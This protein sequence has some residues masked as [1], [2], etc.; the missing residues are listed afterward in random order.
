MAILSFNH[1]RNYVN[2]ED[3]YDD[4]SKEMI[5]VGLG[6]CPHLDKIAWSWSFKIFNAEQQAAQNLRGGGLV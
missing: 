3:L 1:S 5:F 6:K 2:E 4:S